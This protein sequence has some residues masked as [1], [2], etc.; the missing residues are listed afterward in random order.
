MYS[1]IPLQWFSIYVLQF[2]TSSINQG[3]DWVSA[4]LQLDS[5]TK[6]RA[7]CVAV[8]S[9]TPKQ[10]T[11]VNVATVSYEILVCDLKKDISPKISGLH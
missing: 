7:K 6:L 1:F 8:R 2:H 11:D 5:N 9:T 4:T 3:S 10:I